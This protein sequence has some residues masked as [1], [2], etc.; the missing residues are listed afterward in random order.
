MPTVL[1]LN[2][3]LTITGTLK[4]RTGTRVGGSKEDLEIGGMDNPII[5]DPVDKTPYIP[6]SSLKG[7]MRSLLEY[8]YNRVGWR[9]DRNRG[10]FQEQRSG[11]PCG[12][13]QDLSAC[14]VC[15]IFGPH[16]VSRHDLGPS[17]I[18]V[19]DAV[20]ADESKAELSKLLEEGLQYSEVKTENTIARRTGAALNPRQM[21]RVPKG[22]KFNLNISLRVFEGDDEEKMKG[23][24]REALSMLEQDYLGGSGT[25]GYGWVE[26]ED[27]KIEG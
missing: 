22:A 2:K 17:R 20:L 1:K 11:E 25:R 8:K 3:Y 23:Y 18:I 4:C 13:T 15:T 10:V 16:K 21:E 19:R 12:C 14:P 6:G 9:S 26:I 5:R 24:I 7:K 27:L